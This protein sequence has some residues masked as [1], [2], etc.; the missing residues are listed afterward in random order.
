MLKFTCICMFQHDS[1]PTQA[2]LLVERSP[3]RALASTLMITP[4]SAASAVALNHSLR[5][6]GVTSVTMASVW[7]GVLLPRPPVS[8]SL[9]CGCCD[10]VVKWWRMVWV[11]R[12]WLLLSNLPVL[13]S[14]A[15]GCYDRVVKQWRLVWVW[16]CRGC[17]TP[18]TCISDFGLW[19]LGSCCKVVDVS[20]GVKIMLWSGGC[21]HGCG[22]YC[23]V[24]KW[25]MSLWVWMLWGEGGGKEVLF[26]FPLLMQ[27]WIYFG[28]FIRR[29]EQLRWSFWSLQTCGATKCFRTAKGSFWY[30]QTHGATKCFRTA[31]GSFWS[32][33]THGATK[34]FRTAKG[35]F[36]SLQTDM[37]H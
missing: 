2:S 25:W 5:Q 20:L 14:L 3:L 37:S 9:A 7:H 12:G 17:P 32:L 6:R 24:V 18:P 29:W 35:S 4:P 34:C 22:C 21:Q 16:V 33:Q 36:R 8:V 23:H 10:R 11:G 26:W 30:L 13:V 19:M 15:C 28:P 1:V 27:W 31:K